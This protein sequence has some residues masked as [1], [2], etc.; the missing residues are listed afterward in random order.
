MAVMRTSGLEVVKAAV[1]MKNGYELF[2]R[3]LLFS[4]DAETAHHLTIAL[5]QR[6]V[7]FRSRAA[8]AQIF[9]AVIE[10][11]NALWS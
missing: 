11:K 10:T 4:L 5:L 3:P 7:A 8:R 1:Q 9:S 6:R 2:V